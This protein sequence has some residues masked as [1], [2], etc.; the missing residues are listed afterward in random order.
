MQELK[1]IVE[2]QLNLA[3]KKETKESLNAVLSFINDYLEKE[4]LEF[5]LLMQ[6]IPLDIG[7]RPAPTDLFQNH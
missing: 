2:E 4:E 1:I 6:E 7:K 5:E 3:K